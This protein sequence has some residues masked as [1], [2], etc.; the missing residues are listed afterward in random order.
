MKLWIPIA[1]ALL[2]VLA[3]CAVLLVRF[4]MRRYAER[5]LDDYQ[6]ELLD[7]HYEEVE[8]MYRQVRGWRHDYKNHLQTMKV[9]LQNK[10]YELLDD[11]LNTLNAD[12]M[13][14]DTV[15]KTGNV[16]VDAIL[17]SK[18]TLAQNRNIQVNA[19][20]S[21]PEKLTVTQTDLCVIIG[22]LI[23]NAIESTM[24]C[25]DTGERFIR[26]Y[27]GVFKGQLYISVS[28]SVGGKINKR[29]RGDYASTKGAGHGFGLKRMDTVVKKCGGYIN[30]Q[31]EGD[32]FATEV[33][34]P[35]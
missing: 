19:A 32:V 35:L 16:M 5:R 14:I 1:A 9:H 6:R 29:G 8:N 2:T 7:R 4:L 26:V 34:L 31:D 24:E 22:N 10:D 11:Y 15:I 27:I 13:E 33:M 3:I 21:V 12:L 20:A 25:P 28:N 23:D 17:N 30:R 18:L